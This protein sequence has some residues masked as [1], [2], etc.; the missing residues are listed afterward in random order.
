MLATYGLPACSSSST[1]VIT[2][3]A[4]ATKNL[5]GTVAQLLAGLDCARK[6]QTYGSLPIG[7]K[8]PRNQITRHGTKSSAD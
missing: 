2:V 6:A 3:Q 7:K 4:N 8:N 5:R 1:S